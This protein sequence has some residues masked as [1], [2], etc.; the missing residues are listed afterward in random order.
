MSMTG[1]LV[2]LTALR[3]RGA[4]TED[5]FIRAKAQV[6]GHPPGERRARERLRPGPPGPPAA[7]RGGWPLGAKVA[8]A[9]LVLALVVVLNARAIERALAGWA[10]RHADWSFARE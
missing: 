7:T 9:I 8:V 1:D 10:L 6:L 2:R 3:D 5:E 4:L